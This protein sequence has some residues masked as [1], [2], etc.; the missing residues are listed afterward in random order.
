[1]RQKSEQLE[2]ALDR[3]GEAPRNQLSGEADPSAMS[4]LFPVLVGLGTR[5]RGRR[6][7]GR[8]D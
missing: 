3:R 5:R 8:A 7:T 1:M 2:L 4:M 6:L